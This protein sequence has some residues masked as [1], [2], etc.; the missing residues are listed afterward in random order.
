M[1]LVDNLPVLEPVTE[2]LALGI[3]GSANKVGVGLVRYNPSVGDYSILANPR[4]TYVTPP[5]SGFR[6]RE[7]AQHHQRHVVPLLF[8]F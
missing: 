4:E 7:T 3:E 1:Y 2:V 5:G 6:P 8:R